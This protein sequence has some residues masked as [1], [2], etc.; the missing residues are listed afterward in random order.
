[1]KLYMN[2]ATGAI[3]TYN[4]WWYQNESGEIVNAV[5]M[6]EVVE[7]VKDYAGEWKEVDE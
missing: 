6:G 7:V 2:T 5:D 4:G 1:M 3:D